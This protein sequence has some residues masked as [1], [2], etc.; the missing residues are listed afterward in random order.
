ML[1]LEQLVHTVRSEFVAPKLET[2][3]VFGDEQTFTGET[4]TIQTRLQ[5]I[6]SWLPILLM[7]LGGTT[8]SDSMLGY[9]YRV[10]DSK[11]WHYGSDWG[12]IWQNCCKLLYLQVGNLLPLNYMLSTALIIY[13]ITYLIICDIFQIR[14]TIEGKEEAIAVIH[15]LSSLML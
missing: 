6:T 1:F 5:W 3:R 13:P 4:T 12:I 2:L 11:K 14:L 10:S 9:M 8:S 15:I 7:I